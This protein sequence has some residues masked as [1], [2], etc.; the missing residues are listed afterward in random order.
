MGAAQLF[1]K[2]SEDPGPGTQVSTDLVRAL[3]VGITSGYYEGLKELV[4]YKFACIG[5]S[6]NDYIL[7]RMHAPVWFDAVAI[8]DV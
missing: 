2:N 5:Q 8:P 7:L 6:S 4:R 1:H 3:A